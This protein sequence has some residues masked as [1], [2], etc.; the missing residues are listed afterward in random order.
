MRFIR[1]LFGWPVT[2]LAA[3]IS[4]VLWFG[5]NFGGA[6]VGAY[7]P[8]VAGTR[9]TRIEQVDEYNTRIWGT[10]LKIRNCNFSHLEWYIGTPDANAPADILFEESTKQRN[11]GSFSFGPWVV[12]LTPDEI[13]GRSYAVVYHRCHPFWLTE[14]RFYP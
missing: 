9:I 14:S 12:H 8:V 6:I 7:L 10:S 1:N 13:K 4:S 3:L 11:D 5:S 2:L